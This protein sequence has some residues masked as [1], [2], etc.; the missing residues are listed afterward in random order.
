MSI[1][2]DLKKT[3]IL[4]VKAT[5]LFGIPFVLSLS[6]ASRKIQLCMHCW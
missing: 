5:E 6:F 3:M 4:T 2:S 1:N